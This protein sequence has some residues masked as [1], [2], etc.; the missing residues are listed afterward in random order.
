MGINLNGPIDVRWCVGTGTTLVNDI[1]VWTFSLY[2]SEDTKLLNDSSGCMFTLK[3]VKMRRH[4]WPIRI[5][6]TG[7]WILYSSLPEEKA[8]SQTI[9]LPVSCISHLFLPLISLVLLR[10]SILHGLRWLWTMNSYYFLHLGNVY[11][12]PEW[13]S[14]Q[15]RTMRITTCVF[16]VS[17]RAH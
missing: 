1:E 6:G 13:A 8:C 11:L 17:E 9:R 3:L 12:N 15:Y 10:S 14:W 16:V 7:F 5:V 4:I 2:R